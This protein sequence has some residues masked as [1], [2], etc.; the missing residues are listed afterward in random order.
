M[1][2]WQLTEA[3]TSAM[4]NVFRTV[5]QLAEADDFAGVNAGEFRVFRPGAAW[6]R[7]LDEN[8]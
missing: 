5:K 4:T 8:E 6:A 7:D 1:A 2:F 3:G